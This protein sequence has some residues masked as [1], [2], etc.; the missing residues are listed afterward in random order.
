MD[1][2]RSLNKSLPPA[3]PPKP[4]T[5]TPPESLLQAF[6]T[7]ALSVTN[8]YKTAAVDQKEARQ[9]G[10]QDALDELLAFLDKENLGL[11]DG[12]GWRVRQWATE[13]LDGTPPAHT[14]SDSDEDRVEVEKRNGSSSPVLQQKNIPES[15]QRRS[16]S[17]S[18]SPARPEDTSAAPPPL[19]SIPPPTIFQAPTDVF[20][21]R[22]VH[23]LPQDTD[24]QSGDTTQ[25]L[26]IQTDTGTPA[27]RVEFTPRSAR[28]ALRHSSLSSR[29]NTRSSTSVRTLGPGAGSK[30]RVT[31]GD[32]FD[33]SNLGDSKDPGGPAG[34]RSRLI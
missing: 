18:S 17:R 12:E 8:L 33:I 5:V 26:T 28:T 25:N 6:R 30:R 32:F 11:G 14:G 31:F 20:T 24:M 2:M 23:Q 27:V 34:K 13:R 19:L 15:A 7:A 4:R 9:S 29:H 16:P 22:S 21:F 1:S 10:Y 3:S